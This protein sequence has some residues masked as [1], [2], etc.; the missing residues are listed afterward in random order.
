MGDSVQLEQLDTSI[1]ARRRLDGVVVGALVG[2]ATDGV[3][4]VDF[5]GN[6]E[7][8]P[9]VARATAVLTQ[10][11][12]GRDIALLFEGGEP[13]KPIVI[14]V[15]AQPQ[16][17]Q[18]RAVS[19]VRDDERLELTADREIVLRCGDASITLTRAGKVLIRGAYVSSR[20]SGVN[21]IKGGAVHIN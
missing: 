6:P 9:V 17:Q 11:D 20:S 10:E 1:G 18:P 14:G 5:S 16:P 2:L 19:I 4:L 8:S 13:A 12:V 15:M 7:D 3:P 21:R